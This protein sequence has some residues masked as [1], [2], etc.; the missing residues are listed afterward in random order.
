MS[1]NNTNTSANGLGVLGMVV[2]GILSWDKVHHIGWL[3][4]DAAFGWFYLLFYWIN[5][6]LLGR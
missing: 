6:S 3:F 4:L 5:Y 2:A 1:D